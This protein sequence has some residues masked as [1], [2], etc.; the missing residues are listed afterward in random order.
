METISRPENG[1]AASRQFGNQ[2]ANP[3]TALRLGRLAADAVLLVL[4]TVGTCITYLITRALMR[5]APQ[6]KYREERGAIFSEED[7]LPPTLQSYNDWIVRFAVF[8]YR[9]SWI[10]TWKHRNDKHLCHFVP[11]CSE[12]AIL[13]TRKY[14]LIRGLI[15]IGGRFRRCNSAYQGDYLDFP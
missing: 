9:K 15:L 12:Y 11:S 8:L 5:Y 14:G 2:P 6:R 1:S 10:H 13:A 7:V 3:G 4:G